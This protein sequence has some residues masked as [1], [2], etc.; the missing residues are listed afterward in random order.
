[1][2]AYEICFVPNSNPVAKIPRRDI[3]LAPPSFL[4]MDARP[5]NK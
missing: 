2:D 1:M 5:H 3:E 4:P